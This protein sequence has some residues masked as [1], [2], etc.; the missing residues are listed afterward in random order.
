MPV[1]GTILGLL[2]GA[3]D[4]FFVTPIDANGNADALPLG[5]PIPTITA[6]DPTVTVATSADG[7]SALVTAAAGA[8]PGTSFNLNWAASY[9]DPSG[10]T[11]NIA[12][13]AN[14]PILTPP[15]LLPVGGVFNQG[16]PAAAPLKATVKK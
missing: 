1:T 16:S 11:V 9:T 12:A 14:V 6:D 4:T 2:P 8:T 7:L 5:S 15:V 3:A 10:E 13:K